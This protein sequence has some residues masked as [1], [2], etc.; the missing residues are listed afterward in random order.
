M[1][2]LKFGSNITLNFT[3]V[4]DQMSLGLVDEDEEVSEVTDRAYWETRASK[5]TLAMVDQ[6][7]DL[8][9]TLSPDFELKYNKF[10]IGLA[11]NGQINNFVI[12]RPKKDF[13][14]FEIRIPKSEEMDEKLEASSL[15]MLEYDSKWR[16]YR[17]RLNKSDI[18]TKK[19]IILEL[20]GLA[21]GK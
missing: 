16:R 15:D 5:Q 20:L 3:K 7:L 8:I 17:I 19:D 4:L 12:L 1:K 6:V 14:R 21:Y 11:Q 13:V 2:A 18:E 9:K 10:Y